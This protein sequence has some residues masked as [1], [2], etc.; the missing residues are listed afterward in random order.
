MILHLR[1]LII[2]NYHFM[3]SCCSIVVDCYSD[4]FGISD[5]SCWFQAAHDAIKQYV[6]C[7]FSQL[8]LDISGMSC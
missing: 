2:D 7:R 3:D 1:L 5:K 6:A 4:G 8:L